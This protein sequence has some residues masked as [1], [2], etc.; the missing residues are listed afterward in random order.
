MKWQ[1]SDTKPELATPNQ[2]HRQSGVFIQFNPNLRNFVGIFANSLNCSVYWT[3]DEPWRTIQSRFHFPKPTN[4]ITTSES[5]DETYWYHLIV[6]YQHEC[7][8][9]QPKTCRVY[10]NTQK[11]TR[12]SWQFFSQRWHLHLCASG[13]IK[14]DNRGSYTDVSKNR[15]TLKSWIL[16]GVVHY[17]PSILG[18]SPYFWKHPYDHLTIDTW[19]NMLPKHSDNGQCNPNVVPEVLGKMQQKQRTILGIF[20][21]AVVVFACFC[22]FLEFACVFFCWEHFEWENWG[23]V[24]SALNIMWYF[25]FFACFFSSIYWFSVHVF[26]LCYFVCVEFFLEFWSGS[27]EAGGIF[28]AFSRTS[29]TAY[30]PGNKG[31]IRPY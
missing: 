2:T 25:A 30:H 28:S 29:R 3:P 18:G 23:Y 20:L 8:P 26:L 1:E 9:P 17:K 24:I 16:I 21:F 15:G 10:G 5:C 7:V 12:R 6:V 19:T 27:C 11:D 31:L 22:S 14:W 4:Y 13:F